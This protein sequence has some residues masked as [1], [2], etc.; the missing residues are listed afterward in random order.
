VS[1]VAWCY[2]SGEIHFADDAKSVPDGGLVFAKHGDQDK[3]REAVEIV[4][5]HAYDGELLLVGGLAL[6]ASFENDGLPVPPMY[7]KDPVTVLKSFQAE[8][9]KRLA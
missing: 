5:T 3:I 9:E 7:E 2:R 4:A 1:P 8:V 6:I